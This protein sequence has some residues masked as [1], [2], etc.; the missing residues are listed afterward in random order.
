MQTQTLPCYLIKQYLIV[1]IN[2]YSEGLALTDLTNKIHRDVAHFSYE[3]LGHDD[4]FDFLWL[5]K[6]TQLIPTVPNRFTK[7]Y[8]S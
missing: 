5:W 6:R 1:L 7:T 4:Y 3:A 8:D 2:V